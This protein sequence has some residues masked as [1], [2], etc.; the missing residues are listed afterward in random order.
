VF[1]VSMMNCEKF[2]GDLAAT[3]ADI[4]ELITRSR[5]PAKHPSA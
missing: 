2:E 3:K 1:G 4:N 5:H